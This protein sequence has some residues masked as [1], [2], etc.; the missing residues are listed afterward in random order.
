MFL[1]WLNDACCAL[2][3]FMSWHQSWK[4]LHLSFTILY[5]YISEGEIVLLYSSERVWQLQFQIKIK[6]KISKTTMVV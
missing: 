3:V 2:A 4:V 6:I 5:F 1:C